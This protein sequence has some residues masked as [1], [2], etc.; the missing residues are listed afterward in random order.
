MEGGR[1]GASD[2]VSE[3]IKAGAIIVGNR[4]GPASAVW[5]I[6]A[7]LGFSFVK[8]YAPPPALRDV[9]KGS[10]LS[11]FLL[12][13][14]SNP[15]DY[16]SLVTQIRRTQQSSLAFAPLVYFC[17]SPSR[18]VVEAC[19]SIGID[20]VMTMPFT[21]ER[22]RA[23]LMRQIETPQVYFETEDYFGPDRRRLSGPRLA[24]AFLRGLPDAPPARR[25]EI[26]RSLAGGVAVIRDEIVALHV[27]APA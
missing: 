12:A 6:A 16:A 25:L 24:D 23:R 22:V 10:P 9:A 2:R 18:E 17:E 14:T 8:A 11:F 15:R 26:R 3:M 20:D 21:P 13:E 1:D 7:D 4:Q 27:P 19:V 5:D